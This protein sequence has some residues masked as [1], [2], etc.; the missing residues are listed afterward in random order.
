M[1]LAL[2]A[3]APRQTT[4]GSSTPPNSA[5]ATA[6][7]H[8]D[9]I[10]EGHTTDDRYALTGTLRTST[11]GTLQTS[12]RLSCSA[13]HSPRPIPVRLF[14]AP[15]VD[16]C[17]AP[18]GRQSHRATRALARNLSGLQGCPS[19]RTLRLC[20]S[21]SVCSRVVPPSALC[22]SARASPC[23]APRQ[24]LRYNPKHGPSCCWS[25]DGPKLSLR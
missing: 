25:P 16:G 24:S 19:L 17:L 21:K 3:V 7:S 13:D 14:V 18:P 1:P 6:P 2:H 15:F 11:A 8:S 4:T 10:F 22:G 20:A 12:I 9:G 5:G 23:L